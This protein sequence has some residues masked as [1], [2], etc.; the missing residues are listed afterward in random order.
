MILLAVALSKSYLPSSMRAEYMSEVCFVVFACVWP[1]LVCAYLIASPIYAPKFYNFWAQ[2]GLEAVTTVFWFAGFISLAAWVGKNDYDIPDYDGADFGGGLDNLDLDLDK[3]L[4]GLG[5]RSFDVVM[6]LEK[7]KGRGSSSSD[8]EVKTKKPT[9]WIAAAIASATSSI[10]WILFMV[11]LVTFFL[12]LK[13]H[14]AD[15]AKSHLPS[16]GMPYNGEKSGHEMNNVAIAQPAP[17]YTG[18]PY[19]QP[20]ATPVNVYPVHPTPPPQQWQQ[21]PPPQQPYGQA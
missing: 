20:A 10:M 8:F 15:P 2:L 9:S 1:W 14:R 6:A 19:P 21:S 16:T 4:D 7:R 11:T 12:A 5:R 13:R 17:Q 18:Q 3:I